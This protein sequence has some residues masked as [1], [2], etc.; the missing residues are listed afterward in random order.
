MTDH[1]HSLSLPM[2]DNEDFRS[3]EASTSLSMRYIERIKSP[4]LK[5]SHD[6]TDW[7]FEFL[8]LLKQTVTT[9]S[10]ASGAGWEGNFDEHFR[11]PHNLAGRVKTWGTHSVIQELLSKGRVNEAIDLEAWS[12]STNSFFG[13]R[14]IIHLRHQLS[15]VATQAPADAPDRIVTVGD[16]VREEF[17]G[18]EDEDDMIHVGGGSSADVEVLPAYTDNTTARVPSPLW[19]LSDTGADSSTLTERQLSP[20]PHG[21]RLSNGEDDGGFLGSPPLSPTSPTNF[22][23]G[24]APE[25]MLTISDEPNSDSF[26]LSDNLYKEQFVFPEGT[27][28]SSQEDLRRALDSIAD[29]EARE[30]ADRSRARFPYRYLSSA[31][32]DTGPYRLSIS[33][34]PM[35]NEIAPRSRT[36]DFHPT[37]PSAPTSASSS[38]TPEARRRLSQEM[39]ETGHNMM[40]LGREV[41]SM[42]I[43]DEE[44]PAVSQLS[45]SAELGDGSGGFDRRVPELDDRWDRDTRYPFSR[46]PV[47]EDVVSTPRHELQGGISLP[48]HELYSPPTRGTWNIFRR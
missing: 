40:R 42:V 14:D 7:H 34:P 19:D 47:D 13:S 26:A 29:M 22:A 30:E 3:R 16:T 45:S 1:F 18:L 36:I 37:L 28:D 12:V 31:S 46:E 4:E 5:S 20:P 48:R 32:H 23:F 44:G 35:T 8:S 39:I 21:G 2:N 11:V 6:E 17:G 15:R 24:D 33:P 38:W 41:E 27:P 25:E 9:I 43:S 10:S